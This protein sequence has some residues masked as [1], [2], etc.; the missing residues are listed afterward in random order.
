LSAA[1][2]GVGAVSSS[3]GMPSLATALFTRAMSRKRPRAPS[4]GE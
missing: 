2:Y 3:A 4:S 1:A